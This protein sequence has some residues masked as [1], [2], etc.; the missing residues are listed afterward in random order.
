MR[1]KVKLELASSREFADGNRDCGYDLLAPL[2]ADGRLDI[3]AWQRRRHDNWVR[4]FRPAQED[5]WG[6][7]W[8][9]RLG[10]FLVFGYGID[11][12]EAVLEDEDAPFALGKE[13]SIIEYDGHARRFHVA[14]VIPE[15]RSLESAA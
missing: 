12:E 13:I 15:G 3:E 7:L 2:D 14:A 5:G 4:R 1:Y 6:R 11:S 8:H 9:D 10:W